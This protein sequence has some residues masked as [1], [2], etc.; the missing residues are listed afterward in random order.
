MLVQISLVIWSVLCFTSASRGQ[1]IVGKVL[2]SKIIQ[3]RPGLWSV[4]YRVKLLGIYGADVP[5]G[6]VVNLDGSWSTSLSTNVQKG[7]ALMTKGTYFVDQAV[8]KSKPPRTRR[9]GPVFEDS[10]RIDF[11]TNMSPLGIPW[12]SQLKAR[13]VPLFLKALKAFARRVRNWKKEGAFYEKEDW[14]RIYNGK[15]YYLFALAVWEITHHGS[16]RDVGQFVPILFSAVPVHNPAPAKALLKTGII[17][18]HEQTHQAVLSTRRAL[19]MFW[20]LHHANKGI[21][22]SN[23]EIDRALMAY[24]TRALNPISANYIR[25]SYYH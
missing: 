5:I 20:C 10:Q 3:D 12:N 19:W 9:I 6:T 23:A 8:L 18:A 2:G 21:R 13:E 24:I 1:V 17:H 7:I 22:P 15:N 11:R 16:K 4:Q 14:A 25:Y